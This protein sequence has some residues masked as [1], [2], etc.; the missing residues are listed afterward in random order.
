VRAET[1]VACPDHTRC[2]GDTSST[3]SAIF[4]DP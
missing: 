1:K 3:L 2:V 4:I